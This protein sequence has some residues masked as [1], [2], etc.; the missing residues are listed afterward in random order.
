VFSANRGGP[1]FVN[2][3][4]D[5]KLLVGSGQTFGSLEII[6]PFHDDAT[7]GPSSSSFFQPDL[8][9]G[10]SMT[11]INLD[12][13]NGDLHIGTSYGRVL[14]YRLAAYRKTIHDTN[15]TPQAVLEGSGGFLGGLDSSKGVGRGSA[16]SGV[17]KPVIRPAKEPLDIPSFAPSPPELT[18]D[19]KILCSSARSSPDCHVQGWNVFDGYVMTSNPILSSENALLHPRYSRSSVTATTLGPLSTT[20]LVAP[21]KRRLSRNLQVK[22]EESTADS[23]KVFPTSSLGM[24]DLLTPPEIIKEE[25]SILQ[26]RGKNDSKVKMKVFPNPNKLIYSTEQFSACYDATSNPRKAVRDNYQGREVDEEDLIE[27]E[28]TDIPRRYRLMIRPPFY[29]VTNFDYT[30]YNDTGIWVGWDY[31]PSFANSFAC[32]VLTLLYFIEEI[33]STALQLQLCSN[34][35]SIQIQKHARRETSKLFKCSIRS[36]QL[37][38]P[39]HS[40]L[41]LFFCSR[42]VSNGRTWASFQYHR[43]PFCKWHGSARY[44]QQSKKY[45]SS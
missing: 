6:T 26:R 45:R 23:V 7:A 2:F 33:R 12:N 24:Y 14:R 30:L 42:C 16:S 43:K 13:G 21:S 28:D 34:E 25:I 27:S 22:L 11:T 3:L 18:I 15:R 10:E 17:N 32:S 44:V 37:Y 9:A 31:A 1:R 5:G 36:I 19:P 29:K 8:N 41:W 4:P 40:V 38:S 35:M 39:H 20:A